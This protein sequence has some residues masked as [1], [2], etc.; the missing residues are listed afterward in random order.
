[1]AL[2]GHHAGA[3]QAVLEFGDDARLLREQIL[4]FAGQGLEQ[5]LNARHI[6]RGL[7]QRARVLLQGGISVQ[8]E[9]IEVVAPR[10]RVLMPIENLRF[11]FDLQAAQLFLEARYRARQFGQIEVDRVH[12][13]I[14][15]SPEDAHLSGVVQHGVE[16]IGID[17]GH[18]HAFRRSALASGQHRSAAR[19]RGSRPNPRSRPRPQA[20]AGPSHAPT[21]RA[22]TSMNAEMSRSAAAAGGRATGAAATAG[23]AATSDRRGRGRRGGVTSR[24]DSP[25]RAVALSV[26]SRRPAEFH[27]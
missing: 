20:P 19:A 27:C 12:L 26:R 21:Q 4:R 10:F 5:S 2:E 8:L 23:I 11:G 15:T 17:T 6:A 24:Q 14:E 16:Q 1:M 7:G 9:R 22:A 3:H 25:N 18:L 13:L